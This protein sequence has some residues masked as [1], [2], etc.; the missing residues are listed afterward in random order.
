MN[1]PI[2][3]HTI[4]QWPVSKLVEAVNSPRTH[5]RQQIRKL[6]QG[7]QEFGFV[8]PILAAP[9]G[10]IIAGHARRIAAQR[11]QM[12]EVPVIVLDHLTDI[13]RRTL[14]LFDNRLPLD[15][16]WDEDLL[17]LQLQQLK[18][19]CFNLELTGFETAETERL[20]MAE[21]AAILRDQDAVPNPPP[22]PMSSRGDLWTLGEHRVLCGDATDLADVQ[23]LMSGDQADLI[24]TDP[25]YNVDYE[26]YTAD[27]MKIE[28]DSMSST[29]FRAFLD[30]VFNSY[31]NIVKPSASAYVF[32]ASR[33]QIEF[34]A[35]LEQAGF[36]VRCQIVWVKNTFGWGHARYKFRH[37]P[38]FYC[39]V[40]GESD[41]WYGD[42]SES[43]VW[44]ANKP[45]ANR[46]HPTTKPVE[47]LERAL[48][49]SSRAEDVVV[50]FFGG[51]GSTLIACERRCR[52]A[53]LMEIDPKFVG[54]IIR[55]WQQYT[56]GEARL[57]A[58]GATYREVASTRQRVAA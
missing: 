52:K 37:E 2:T 43:T 24:I 7:I 36:V 21:S 53:R 16:G 41:A 5:S 1:P 33:W 42:K 10:A 6:M 9:D 4:S 8:N 11:L 22:L 30:S 48:L 50:D 26:G 35:A 38:M 49:N 29:A 15:G 32:H 14:A 44:E 58:D 54:V 31:R 12:A 40:D 17:R 51:S 39:Y 28:G 45:A 57:S 34:Q 25:P 47:L 56:G 19:E 23:K 55:R 3:V 46:L 20:L 13:Q 18:D 27:R